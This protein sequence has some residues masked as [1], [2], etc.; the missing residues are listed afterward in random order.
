MS[1]ILIGTTVI[2]LMAISKAE[3]IGG[4]SPSNKVKVV[5]NLV[6]V[7]EPVTF[8]GDNA[9]RVWEALSTTATPLE[10]FGRTW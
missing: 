7:Q 10:R 3:Y 6:G 2:N 4:G 9:S 5:L 8:Y 1:F